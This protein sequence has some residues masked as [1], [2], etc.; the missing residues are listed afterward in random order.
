MPIKASTFADS[1]AAAVEQYGIQN[2]AV[3][4]QICDIIVTSGG[5]GYTTAP[6]VSVIGDGSNALATATISS[7]VVT[8]I[9]MNNDSSA[10]GSG[11]NYA[12]VKLTGGS[13]SVSASARVCISPSGGF[14]SNPKNDLKS[15]MLMFN[16]KPS[17]TESGTFIIDQDFR[18]VSLL[19][20]PT[21]PVTDS[22]FVGGSGSFLRSINF[23]SVSNAFTKD[24]MILGSSSGAK[25]YVDSTG[26]LNIFYHQ[27]EATGF[28]QFTEAETVTE[29]AG[30][31]SGILDSA[32][33]DANSLAYTE[34]DAKPFSGDILYI[35]NRAAVMRAS[36]QT[37]DIKVVIGI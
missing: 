2:A 15:T 32:S 20:N 8:K 30:A 16:T 33:I 24:K 21:I 18:Q 31:G 6:T 17:G 11:F 29:I 12:E 14:G 37:E 25:A 1:A 27:T 26:P 5:S 19:K 4:G 13:P 7:G 22:D 9:E 10:F 36:S 35:E 3:S 28:T 23:A 34:G